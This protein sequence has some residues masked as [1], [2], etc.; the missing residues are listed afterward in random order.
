MYACLYICIYVYKKHIWFSIATA[1]AAV[2]NAKWKRIAYFMALID[3]LRLRFHLYVH[4]YALI[5]YFCII[6][7][8]Y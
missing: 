5:F 8:I 4:T 7:E 2:Y 3:N 6:A 1:S